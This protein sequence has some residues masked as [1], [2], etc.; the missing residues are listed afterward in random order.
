M[1]GGGIQEKVAVSPCW[2][3]TYSPGA[4]STAR[5]FT[6]TYLVFKCF[7]H[8]NALLVTTY[9]RSPAL[10]Q[11]PTAAWLSGSWNITLLLPPSVVTLA[12]LGR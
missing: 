12:T 7:V 5:L 1:A 8:H 3:H 10:I 2:V 11:V 6:T 9:L 4:S